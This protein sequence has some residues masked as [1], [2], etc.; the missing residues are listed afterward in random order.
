MAIN[1]NIVVTNLTIKATITKA[2]IHNT[3]INELGEYTSDASSC[4][5]QSDVGEEFDQQEPPPS[6]NSKN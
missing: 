1:N 5:D 3:R 4:S 6:D 2:N